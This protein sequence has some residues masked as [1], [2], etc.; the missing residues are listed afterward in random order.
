MK[1]SQKAAL[2]NDPAGM[3][4]LGIL[5]AWGHGVEKNDDEAFRWF[6]KAA[7]R[8]N[9]EAQCNLA[10]TYLRGEGNVAQNY[11]EAFKWYK[12]AAEQGF[13]LGEFELANMYMS[14]QGAPQ[15]FIEAAKWYRK[16]ADQ[17][18]FNQDA[19]N[20]MGRLGVLYVKGLGVKQDYQEAYFLLGFGTPTVKYLDKDAADA[21]FAALDEAEKHLT[22]EQI[23]AAN[24]RAREWRPAGR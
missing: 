23:S 6:Q 19:V 21:E 13:A 5:Y 9:A 14:G 20:A 3:E 10:N 16:A 2:Q 11:P 1:W 15:D 4:K 18:H 24:K 17:G 12:K 22:P 7:E 8:G